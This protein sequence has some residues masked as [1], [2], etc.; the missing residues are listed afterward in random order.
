MFT[1]KLFVAASL[2]TAVGTVNSAPKPTEKVGPLTASDAKRTKC[3]MHG[4]HLK[5][6]NVRISY[7]IA[8][9]WPAGYYEASKASFPNA[10]SGIMGGCIIMP[11]MPRIQAV[12]FCPKCRI[13]EKKWLA[14]HKPQ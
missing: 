7:G 10:R 6:D 2:L 12:K 9:L 8:P 4:T 1:H 3:E 14:A 13:A 5:V 11:D